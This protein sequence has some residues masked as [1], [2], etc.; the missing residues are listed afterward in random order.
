MTIAATHPAILEI[1][2]F[3]PGKKPESTAGRQRNPCPA[4]HP[5]PTRVIICRCTPGD[6]GYHPDSFPPAPA[7][8]VTPAA[9]IHV[10]PPL[11]MRRLSLALCSLAAAALA[12]AQEGAAPATPEPAPPAEQA[13]ASGDDGTQVSILGYHDFSETEPE[14]AMR[15][16]TSKFRK[17]LEVINQLGIPVVTLDQFQQWKRGEAELPPKCVL[18]TIDDGWRSVYT[19]ALAV[20]RDFNYPFTLFLYKNYVDG[21]NKSLTSD[22]VREL[23]KNGATI[24][25]H[26]VSHP[27][28]ATIKAR[29]AKGD[30]V[31]RKFLR[32]EMGES[33]RFLE[34]RFGCRVTSFAYPG[35]YFSEDMDPVAKEVGYTHL[36][37]VQPGKVRRSSPDQ[38]IPRYMI[39][40]NYDRIFELATDFR[41]SPG[42]PTGAVAG[43]TQ[44]TPFPVTPAAGSIV[45]NRLPEISADLSQVPELDPA[46]VVMKVGGFGAVPA[47]LDATSKRLSWQVNR[48]LRQRLCQVSVSWK[49][50]AGKEPEA[51]LRWSFQ[52]DRD[53]AYLPGNN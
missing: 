16:R 40:G 24:G 53:A 47:K 4:N 2:R 7:M 14:T 46:S 49:T 39:L 17:Q 38:A 11:A 33:K 23:V 34:M 19:D 5:R 27:Y 13:P 48:R 36:F 8:P 6:P 43:L 28:P 15:I 1:F 35:G 10:F 37:T 29:R 22:M 20:L 50:T 3:T 51:P 30:E 31:Y 44:T 18:I 32:T 45:N 12:S 9:K 21:G 52:I 41:D 25:S 26:S 42:Q